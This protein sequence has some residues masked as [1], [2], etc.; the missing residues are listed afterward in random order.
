MKMYIRTYGFYEDRRNEDYVS[1][2]NTEGQGFM[3]L[4]KMNELVCFPNHGVSHLK[5]SLDFSDNPA[6]LID[7]CAQF[8]RDYMEPGAVLLSDGKCDC[9]LTQRAHTNAFSSWPRE[10]E[11]IVLF[12][13]RPVGVSYHS[14]HIIDVGFDRYYLEYNPDS[15]IVWDAD[16]YYDA[17]GDKYELW[18]IYNNTDKFLSFTDDVMA[19]RTEEGL[20]TAL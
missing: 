15:I 18:G 17:L 12:N 4:K 6:K 11:F 8:A 1:W 20:E 2:I 5:Y 16:R 13:A 14:D 10:R 9:M 7:E 19:R 3:R